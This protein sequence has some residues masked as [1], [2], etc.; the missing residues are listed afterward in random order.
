MKDIKLLDNGVILKIEKNQ[1]NEFDITAL[2]SVNNEIFS[3]KIDE[4]VYIEN[5]ELN[6]SKINELVEKLN[7]IDMNDPQLIDD[8][9]NVKIFNIVSYL[10]F[11]KE[12]LIEIDGKI[13]DFLKS[14]LHLFSLN[15]STKTPFPLDKSDIFSCHKNLKKDRKRFLETVEFYLQFFENIS[16]ER[17]TYLFKRSGNKWIIK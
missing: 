8:L 12:K 7:S 17:G 9:K 2:F 5:N 10:K 11:M 1:F 16:I 13:D 6:E 3:I 15:V 14:S 4:T